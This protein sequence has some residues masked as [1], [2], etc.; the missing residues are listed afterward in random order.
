LLDGTERLN[1]RVKK[2]QYQRTILV[3]MQG[4]ITR[5]IANATARMQTCQKR[6]QLAEILQPDNVLLGDFTALAAGH[7]AIMCKQSQARQTNWMGFSVF[8]PQTSWRESCAERDCSRSPFFCLRSLSGLL[9]P[10][11]RIKGGYRVADRLWTL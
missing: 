6:R 10:I 9:I 1:D 3:E 7:A 4:A 8:F 2:Q 11:G 5:L